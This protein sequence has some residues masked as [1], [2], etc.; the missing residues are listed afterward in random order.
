[1]SVR[2][3]L[4]ALS[5]RGSCD[6]QECPNEADYKIESASG[7]VRRRDTGEALEK[8]IFLC[9]AH[10]RYVEKSGRLHLDW[11]RVLRNQGLLEE[12][13]CVDC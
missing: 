11:E 13:E 5:G 12:E 3:P 6:W 2:E 7:V 1:M 8:P 4:R 9:G 10:W